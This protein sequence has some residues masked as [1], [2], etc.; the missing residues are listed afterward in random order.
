MALNPELLSSLWAV[1][2]WKRC[3]G[4]ED[5]CQNLDAEQGFIRKALYRR[6]PLRWRN[7]LGSY[8]VLKTNFV[9]RPGLRLHPKKQPG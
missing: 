4:D 7:G 6:E 3:G 1:T 2:W 5:R 8:G 9:N